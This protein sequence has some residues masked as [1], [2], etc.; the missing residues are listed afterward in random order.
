MCGAGITVSN[1]DRTSKTVHV[2]QNRR[3]Y[4]FSEIILKL[5]QDFLSEFKN[6]SLGVHWRWETHN[7]ENRCAKRQENSLDHVK[8]IE[9][10][11]MPNLDVKKVAMKLIKDQTGVY[12][13]AP[14]SEQSIIRGV[15][16]SN[17]NSEVKLYFSDDLVAWLKRKYL[18]CDWFLKFPGEV[19][20]LVEQAILAKSDDFCNWPGSAWSSRVLEVRQ[21]RKR[22][23]NDFKVS[24]KISFLDF[25]TDC[26]E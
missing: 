23:L 13:A 3:A 15:I 14:A 17:L 7:W 22:D 25:L 5:S 21:N 18:N 6:I 19:V 20:S 9:C 24:R 10:E 16:D 12:I 2:F 1:G 26:V 8:S 11:I 4:D